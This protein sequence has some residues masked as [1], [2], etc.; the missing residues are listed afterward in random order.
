MDRR[1]FFKIG[2]GA[3]AAG[4]VGNRLHASDDGSDQR[5]SRVVLIRDRSVIGDDGGLDGELLHRMLNRAVAELFETETAGEAWKLVV[6]PDDIVGIKSNVW[7]HLPTPPELEEAIRTEVIGVGVDPKDIAVDDRGVR[8]NP[9]FKRATAFVNVRPLRTHKWSV[10][11]SCL[12]NPIMFVPRPPEYHD[13]SCAPLGAMWRLP[14]LEGKIK[15]NILV[16]LTPQ[17]H[18]VGPHSFS[19]EYIWPYKG[20]IVGVDPV[21]VDATGARIIRAKRDLYF[22]KPSPISPPAHH[23]ELADTRYGLGVS[24]PDAI[25]LVRLGWTDDALI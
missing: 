5:T 7:S 15:L 6:S 21:A 1:Q 23:I 25:D 14:E 13:D 20:L 2:T 17:F 16:V 8:R 10:L 4:V 22:G 11:G 3:I 18:G 12:K 9:V 19:E 24:N